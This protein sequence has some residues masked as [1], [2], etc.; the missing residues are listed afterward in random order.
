MIRLKSLSQQ[1]GYSRGLAAGALRDHAFFETSNFVNT[2]SCRMNRTS[3]WSSSLSQSGSAANTS[4]RLLWCDVF[5]GERVR[6]AAC[7]TKNNNVTVSRNVPGNVFGGIS[8]PIFLTRHVV[9]SDTAFSAE[10]YVLC[11]PVP[12]EMGKREKNLS[13]YM[14]SSG[15]YCALCVP[16]AATAV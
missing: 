7:A 13:P 2:R 1:T 14:Q 15:L 16:Y 9:C 12:I 5:W 4:G 6:G 11:S 3:N 10:T 8:Q